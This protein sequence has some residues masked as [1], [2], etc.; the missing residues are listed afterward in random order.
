MKVATLQKKYIT[1]VPILLSPDFAT[2]LNAV[3]MGRYVQCSS[4]GQIMET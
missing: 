2:K 3:R 4:T 1:R